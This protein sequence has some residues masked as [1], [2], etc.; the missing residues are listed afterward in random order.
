MRNKKGLVHII[1]YGSVV[2]KQVVGGTI[3]KL[4]RSSCVTQ[5][6]LRTCVTSVHRRCGR[7]LN[8]GE[9]CRELHEER[10]AHRWSQLLRHVAET[11]CQDRG[12]TTW[13]PAGITSTVFVAIER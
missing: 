12:Q 7:T 13:H 3:K 9:I 10:V 11:W 5:W 8:M 6:R 2:Q 4:S 1:T